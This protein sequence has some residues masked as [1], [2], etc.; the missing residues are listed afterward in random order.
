MGFNL[1]VMGLMRGVRG[2]R[3]YQG[4][5]ALSCVYRAQSQDVSDEIIG[6]LTKTQGSQSQHSV[7]LARLRVGSRRRASTSIFRLIYLS[8]V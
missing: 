2:A 6:C 3:R 8:F 5:G 7:L 1:L 4:K